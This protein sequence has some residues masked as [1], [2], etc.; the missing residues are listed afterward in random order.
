MTMLDVVPEG[1]MAAS[2]Q[3]EM[4][5]ARLMGANLAHTAVM[6]A[7]VPPGSDLPSVKLSASLIG[8]GVQHEGMAMMGNEE[9]L[10]SGIGVAE[11][12]FSYQTGDLEGAAAY[13]AAAGV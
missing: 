11:S 7:V 3:A 10:R 9:L 6:G 13:T 12:S 5:V 4:L 8:H 2:A 1:L